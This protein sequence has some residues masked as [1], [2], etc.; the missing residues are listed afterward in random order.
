MNELIEA[1]EAKRTDNIDWQKTY[2][3]RRTAT[4]TGNKVN[5]CRYCAEGFPECPAIDVIFGDGVGSDNVCS[6]A[7]YKYAT[8]PRW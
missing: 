5:L 7:S 4:T 3:G 8:A 2:D 1:L 6:C